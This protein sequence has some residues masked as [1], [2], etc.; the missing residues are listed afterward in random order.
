MET[1]GGVGNFPPGLTTVSGDICHHFAPNETVMNI[2]TKINSPCGSGNAD[3]LSPFI[4]V[5]HTN[6]ACPPTGP[7]FSDLSKDSPFSVAIHGMEQAGY[8]SGYSDGTFRPDATATRGQVARM[9]VSAFGLTPVTAGARTA[10]FSDVSTASP[11]YPYVEAAY[12]AG[13]VS[14]YPDGT[15]RPDSNVT[16]GQ[17]A[18]IVVLAAMHSEGMQLVSATVSSFKDVPAGS[19]YYPY[20][21][22]AYKNGLLTGYSDGTFRPTAN[23]TRGQLAR[24]IMLASTPQKALF[25]NGLH[26]GK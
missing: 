14:G 16:R 21:E 8:A 12:R 13:L 3:H 4:D 5:C 24:I 22:T 1:V 25:P 15:F 19:P 18:K 10:H 11:L 23:A 26:P 17:V 9:L 20:V 6:P 7:S 2:Y